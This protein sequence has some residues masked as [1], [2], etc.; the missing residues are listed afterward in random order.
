MPILK[1]KCECGNIISKN[2]LKTHRTR[3]TH[4]YFLGKLNEFYL[5]EKNNDI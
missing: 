4:F 2:K 5:L 3:W 1:V